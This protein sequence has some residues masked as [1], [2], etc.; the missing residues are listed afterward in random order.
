MKTLTL[1]EAATV[2]VGTALLGPATAER[3]SQRQAA[4]QRITTSPAFPAHAATRQLSAQERAELRRQLSEYSRP[5]FKTAA[6]TN[7]KPTDACP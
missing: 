2:V 3:P 7:C 4:Q 5:A 6:P 1:L